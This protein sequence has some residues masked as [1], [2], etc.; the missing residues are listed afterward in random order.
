M[1][2]YKLTTLPVIGNQKRIV[3]IVT[4][5]DLFEENEKY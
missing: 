3:G 2:K 1:I 5:D 4:F